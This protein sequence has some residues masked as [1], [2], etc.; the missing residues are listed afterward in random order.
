[1]RSPAREGPPGSARR[2]TPRPSRGWMRPGTCP[3]QGSLCGAS[4]CVPFIIK[5]LTSALSVRPA[6]FMLS[7]LDQCCR[8]VF[9]SPI[10]TRD[11]A[12]KRNRPL[13]SLHGHHLTWAR[14]DSDQSGCS[15]YT[16]TEL[17]GWVN[18][19][20]EAGSG[21]RRWAGR[22]LDAGGECLLGRQG[23]LLEPKLQ[24]A[25]SPRRACRSVIAWSGTRRGVGSAVL[26][27]LVTVFG[28]QLEQ[29]W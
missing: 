1:M 13:E 28:V 17:P 14:A 24:A 27:G 5:A 15:V 11:T 2:G 19:P 9:H 22:P 25:S 29:G 12:T 21:T 7:G 4:V 18:L 16:R 26:D 8:S 10:R 6:S 23:G 20:R 3:W